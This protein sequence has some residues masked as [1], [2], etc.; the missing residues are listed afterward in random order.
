MR[1]FLGVTIFWSI[2]MLIVTITMF[3]ITYYLINGGNFTPF[4]I[5]PYVMFLFGYILATF[6]F[7]LESKKAK[8]IIIDLIKEKETHHN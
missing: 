1:M 5:I 8:N 4:H 6:A 3:G 7:N 2:W